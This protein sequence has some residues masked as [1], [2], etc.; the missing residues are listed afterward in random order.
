[1]SQSITLSKNKHY[2]ILLIGGTGVGKSCLKN[3]I[4]KKKFQTEISTIGVNY[5]HLDYS[6]KNKQIKLMIT[7][8]AGQEQFKSI[9]KSYYKDCFAV[10]FCFAGDTP[11]SL[12]DAEHYARQFQVN[13]QNSK[14]PEGF[15]PV[16]LFVRNKCDLPDN[17]FTQNVIDNTINGIS[18]FYQEFKGFQN[19]KFFEVSAKEGTNTESLLQYVVEELDKQNVFDAKEQQNVTAILDQNKDKQ[20]DE[21]SQQGCCK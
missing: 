12:K 2:S 18:E 20:K 3:R 10:L 19:I 7:D 6:Y 1:M 11:K 9:T 16:C 21:T 15:T 14:A 8:T 5:Q 4:I 17:I 13:Y